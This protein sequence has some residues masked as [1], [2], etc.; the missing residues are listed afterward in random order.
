M[1]PRFVQNG[2]FDYNLAIKWKELHEQEK[3]FYD[4]VKKRVELS[5]EH[6]EYEIEQ[7]LIDHKTM[8]LKE[9]LRQRQE[10]LQRIED[11]RK[12]EF[13]RRHEIEMR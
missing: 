5:K 12:S 4:E 2:S 1:L 13:Q 6:L 3:Q 9:D 10:E 8:L 7:S 11:F